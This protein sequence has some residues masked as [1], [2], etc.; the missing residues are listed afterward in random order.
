[1]AARHGG[2]DGAGR[3]RDGEDSQPPFYLRSIHSCAQVNPCGHECMYRMCVC[4]CVCQV[5]SPDGRVASGMCWMTTWSQRTLLDDTYEES[6]A[7]QGPFAPLSAHDPT[8]AEAAAGGEGEETHADAPKKKR[9]RPP[10]SKNKVK[11]DGV[12]LQATEDKV[13]QRRATTPP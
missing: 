11:A 10:G 2:R 8:T 5:N 12:K 13:A 9:G 7:G 1:M 3:L 4:V 6:Q